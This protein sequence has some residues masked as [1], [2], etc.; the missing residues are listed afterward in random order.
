MERKRE[1]RLIY[2]VNPNRDGYPCRRTSTECVGWQK[3]PIEG[4][5]LKGTLQYD[6]QSVNIV[7]D[8][9]QYFLLFAESRV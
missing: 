7:P 5:V 6:E 9:W 2:F 3:I 8:P 4:A 1:N